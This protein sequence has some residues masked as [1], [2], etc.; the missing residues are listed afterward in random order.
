[1]SASRTAAFLAPGRYG[2][3]K[4]GG[5]KGLAHAAFAAYYTNYLA[6]PA[7]FIKG[8]FGDGIAGGAVALAAA[9]AI[10]ITFAHVNRLSCLKRFSR[11]IGLYY[12]FS[13]TSK[14]RGKN[15]QISPNI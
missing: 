1:M 8:F 7:E 14:G 9:A 13:Y 3:G 6:N 11:S 4:H 10:V 2:G 15:S 5:D 12:P